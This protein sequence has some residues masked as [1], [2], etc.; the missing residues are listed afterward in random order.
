MNLLNKLKKTVYNFYNNKS[1]SGKKPTIV[2]ISNFPP[3]KCGIATFTQ[4]LFSSME[5]NSQKA[6]N[7]KLISLIDEKK[8]KKKYK[9]SILNINRNDKKDYQNCAKFINSNK[10]IQVVNIQHEFGIFGGLY[11]RFILN[12]LKTVKKPV[13][14]TFHSVIPKPNY[15]FKTL[16][17]KIADQVNYI[18]VMNKTSKKILIND[19]KINQNQIK[20][21]PH[22]VPDYKYEKNVLCKKKLGLNKR[23]VLLTFGFLSQNKG[24]EYVIKALPKLIKNYPNLLYLIV[25]QTHP[26]IKQKEGEKY[27]DKLKELTRRLRLNKNVKF[28]NSYQS[29]Q[30]L[31]EFLKAC[32]IYLCTSVD[33]NQSVSG[34]FSYALSSG[35]PVISTD[36]I[37]AN[38]FKNKKI[39]LIIPPQNSKAYTEAIKN[40]LKDKK[41]RSAMGKK[42]FKESRPMTWDNVSKKYLELF[43]KLI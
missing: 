18:V 5:K 39:G 22:G 8:D 6:L 3:K 30:K 12:F 15:I 35:R 1:Y 28:I 38:E 7:F 32:D 20:T 14:I 2:Y 40:L 19:Y 17:R 4:N 10:K 42:A 43:D 26:N 11:G 25:G 31:I 16:I 36:F 24:I 9:D 37:Q 34:T 41:Q 27:R 23:T 33:P 13:V 29:N 21:I